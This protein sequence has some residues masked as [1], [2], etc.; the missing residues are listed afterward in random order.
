[1]HP[2]NIRPPDHRSDSQIWKDD[3]CIGL[4]CKNVR[5]YIGPV[6]HT[7][8]GI[9]M[10]GEVYEVLPGPKTSADRILGRDSHMLSVRRIINDEN[11]ETKNLTTG[12]P[13]RCSASFLLNS[14]TCRK[15]N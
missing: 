9:V 5:T 1:M 8:S 7:V 6:G 11:V 12:R 14:Y 3:V 4:R 15:V 13:G 2:F 10:V